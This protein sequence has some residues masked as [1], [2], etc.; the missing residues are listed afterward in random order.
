MVD[1]VDLMELVT[2]LG[3]EGGKLLQ[4]LRSQR[5]AVHQEEHATGNARF[6]QAID[7]VDECEGLAGPRRHGDEHL[8][9]AAFNGFFNRGVG[10]LLVR[11]DQRMIIRGL[12]QLV[13]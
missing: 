12:G 9:L 11:P 5:A 13:A 1:L 10:F 6:H 8:T 7:L 4:R 2:G 3:V